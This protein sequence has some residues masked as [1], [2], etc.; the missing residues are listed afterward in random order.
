MANRNNNN[1]NYW[2]RNNRTQYVN[3]EPQFKTTWAVYTLLDKENDLYIVNAFRATKN[4]LIKYT[5]KPYHGTYKGGK[6]DAPVDFVHSKAK[7]SDNIKN[8]FIKMICIIEYPMGAPETLS[9]LFNTSN[10]KITL[11]SKGLVI[12]PN[13][14]GKLKSGKTVKGAVVKYYA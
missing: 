11:D 3:N 14:Q 1:D 7:G 5:V 10:H 4:G 9:V 12:T 8:T 13:G 2:S 6:T